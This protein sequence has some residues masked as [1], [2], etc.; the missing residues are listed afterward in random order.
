[1]FKL[2]AMML[3][4]PAI[5]FAED[6]KKPPAPPAEV[7]ATVDAFKGNWTFDATLTAPGAK[8]QKLATTFNCK[9]VSGGNAVSCEASAKGW[10]AS[11]LVGYD[12]YAKAVRFFQITNQFEVRDHVCKWKGNDL[13]CAALKG[14]T[15]PT[16][17]EVS[18]EMKLRFDK[19][20]LTFTSTTKSKSGTVVFEGKGKR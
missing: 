2:A 9:P 19:N 5:A 1:M 18:D 10:D 15:G 20:T 16:G 7:K 6:A 13:D 8:P 4:V 17:D 11:F 3:L 14:G 12:P